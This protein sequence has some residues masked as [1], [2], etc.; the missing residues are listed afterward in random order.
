[1]RVLIAGDVQDINEAIVHLS[2]L[3][4]L[5]VGRVRHA[6]QAQELLADGELAV[7]IL[8]ASESNDF[9]HVA[10]LAG[11]GARVIHLLSH[12]DAETRDAAFAAGAANV[13]VPPVDSEHL[14][15]AVFALFGRVLRA[16][17][18]C[19]TDI[20]A[21]ITLRDGKNLAA[22]VVDLSMGGMQLL[23]LEPVELGIVVSVRLQ[24]PAPQPFETFAYVVGRA[25]HEHVH[26]H[27]LHA[28][29]VGMLP[30]ERASL[31]EYLSHDA[32]SALLSPALQALI[33]LTPQRLAEGEHQEIAGLRC[34]PLTDLEREALVK[35]KS[36]L[37]RIAVI[38]CRALLLATLFKLTDGTGELPPN[39]ILAEWRDELQLGDEALATKLKHVEDDDRRRAYR[40]V[41]AQLRVARDQL[42]WVLEQARRS[43]K[44]TL[45]V[46]PD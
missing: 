42:E 32:P 2:T 28:R 31:A 34:P 9:D 16:D 12:E 26:G 36:S 41:Q 17:V 4:N 1:M 11:M 29:F 37:A 33:E 19:P 40:N 24:P 8:G 39:E 23:T 20:D 15:Q 7:V 25:S 30:A 10:A 44:V 27:S 18:R 22:K 14:V 38:R 43:R 6:V 3:R 46:K 21:V 5:H 45:K 35:P 13:L